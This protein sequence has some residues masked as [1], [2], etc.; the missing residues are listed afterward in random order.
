M[1]YACGVHP[2]F[3]W[4]FAGGASSDYAI[5]FDAPESPEVPVI[6]PGGLIG[7]ETRHLPLEQGLLPLTARS[8]R[9][10]RSAS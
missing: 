2:G 5:R 6:A 3:R 10:M 1:P 8:L 4:P 9:T 7:R